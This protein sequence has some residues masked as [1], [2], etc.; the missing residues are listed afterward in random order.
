MGRR[1]DPRHASNQ[2]GMRRSIQKALGTGIIVAFTLGTVAAQPSPRILEL[3]EQPAGQ[4]YLNE[5]TDTEARKGDRIFLFRWARSFSRTPQDRIAL[6][7]A[8]KRNVTDSLCSEVLDD[9][10]D[11]PEVDSFFLNQLSK[12]EYRDRARVWLRRRGRCLRQDLVQ[13]AAAAEEEDLRALARLDP[14][15]ARKVIDRLRTQ[16]SHR[17]L[18]LA[19]E[20]Q[21]DPARADLRRRLEAVAVD[22]RAS[23]DA[24]LLACRTL[25]IISWPEQL[26]FMRKLG[27]V[28]GDG[29]PHTGSSSTAFLAEWV[30]EDPDRWVPVMIKWLNDPNRQV[31]NHAVNAL[32]QFHGENHREDALRALLPWLS[33]PRWAN[34]RNRLRLIQSLDRFE[35]PEAIPGLIQIVSSRGDDSERS[36]AAVTLGHYRDPRAIPAMRQAF[37]EQTNAHHRERYLQGLIAC[38]AYPL[39]AQVKAVEG[40]AQLLI[41]HGDQARY[42]DDLLEGEELTALGAFLGRR[43]GDDA[44]SDALVDALGNRIMVLRKENSPLAKQLEELMCDWRFPAVDAF[45][46]A[47]VASDQ[48]DGILLAEAWSRR[49]RLDARVLRAGQAGRGEQ[50]GICAALLGEPGGLLDGN[51]T[52]AANALLAMARLGRL[53]LPFESVKRRHLD[54]ATQKSAEAYLVALDSPEARALLSGRIFGSSGGELKKFTPAL[55]RQLQE[56]LQAHPELDEVFALFTTGYYESYGHFFVFRKGE[57]TVFRWTAGGSTARERPLSAEEWR[58]F[59]HFVQSREVDTW[60]KLNDV[61]GHSAEYQYFHLTRQGGARVYCWS[62]A[63]TGEQQRY[64]ELTQL[65]KKLSIG[66]M[67]LR[68]AAVD[69]NPGARVIFD[70]AERHLEVLEIFGDRAGPAVKLAAPLQLDPAMLRSEAF[71]RFNL[72]PGGG[73][74]FDLKWQKRAA[75]QGLPR[76]DSSDVTKDDAYLNSPAWRCQTSQGRVRALSHGSYRGLYLTRP[77]RK[78]RKLAD[79]WFAFPVVST[80]GRWVVVSKADGNWASPNPL[81][82]LDLTTGKFTVVDIPPADDLTCVAYIPQRGFLARAAKN[83]DA[84]LDPKSKGPDKPSYSLINPS[85]GAVT[86][87]SG[88]FSPLQ[89]LGERPLQPTSVPG[90]FYAARPHTDGTEL[91]IYCPHSFEFRP[92][93]VYPE[94]RVSSGQIWV[95]TD[96]KKLYVCTGRNLLEFPAP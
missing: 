35:C 95:D 50:A 56:Q 69:A 4:R 51:D 40:Y 32:A 3:L 41:R 85:T 79:G 21:M 73:A 22:A 49:A 52:A 42:G 44:P 1:G 11:E 39:E 60:P 81:V 43:R 83:E 16:T 80:D 71:Q 19:V 26:Q 62:P 57:E 91:G 68:H 34:G 65:F 46:Q 76:D 45:L 17:M 55:E 90:E 6:W 58:G 33:D 28:P 15:A 36:Y 13:A 74:W 14:A 87:I 89:G 77:G 20:V 8:V 61:A 31:H 92:L 48:A 38:G 72:K 9:L 96:A 24:R 82:R 63:P 75:P 37:L 86:P 10:P 5:E 23:A 70:S 64:W 84:Q 93:R 59:K 25:S 18:V 47:Q 66:P 67:Q 78:P 88:E 12:L 94:L 7:P 2:V 27:S 29:L 53:P 54:P 30:K